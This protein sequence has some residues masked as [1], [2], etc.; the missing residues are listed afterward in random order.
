MPRPVIK[1]FKKVL[2]F[3]PASYV[4]STKINRIITTG[5]D[6]ASADQASVTDP[7]IPT[8][9]IVKY[10]E[11][12]TSFVNL[13]STTSFI[14]VAIELLRSGQSSIDPRLVGGDPIR[15]QVFYQLQFNVGKDQ[16]SN[17]VFRFKIPKKYQRVRAGDKWI[18]VFVSNAVGSESTQIIYKFYE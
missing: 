10:F 18:F 8:G 14:N 16:N 12:Q 2:N 15:N 3:A 4:S 17:H 6:G 13:A 7:T 9:A 1:S 11:I 5:T